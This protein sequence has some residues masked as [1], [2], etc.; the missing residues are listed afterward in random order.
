MYRGM[1][2]AQ[3]SL[4]MYGSIVTVLATNFMLDM[5]DLDVR[6]TTTG[7]SDSD[8]CWLRG[9]SLAHRKLLRQ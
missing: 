1:G 3:Y 4:S 5:L 2:F 9:E 6:K 7:S 8:T